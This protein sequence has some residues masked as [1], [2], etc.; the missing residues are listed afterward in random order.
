MCGAK[1][2]YQPGCYSVYR[3]Y[4]DVTVSTSSPKRYVENQLVILQ[5]YET[6]LKREH[7]LSNAYKCA[8]AQSYFAIARKCLKSDPKLYSQLLNKALLLS[9]DFKAQGSKRTFFYNFGQ[10]ILGFKRTE[11]IVSKFKRFVFLLKNERLT[12]NENL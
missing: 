7:R 6:R 10:S 9:P 2:V 4:G 8:L 11:L 12:K 1:V 3:R 5:K